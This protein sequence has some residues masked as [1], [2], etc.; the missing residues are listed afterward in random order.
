MLLQEFQHQETITVTNVNTALPRRLGFRSNV[1]G[2]RRLFDLAHACAAGTV[3]GTRERPRL[4]LSLATMPQQARVRFG[5]HLPAVPPASEPVVP[6]VPAMCGAG[7]R[8][9]PKAEPA[10]QRAKAKAK[11]AA[12]PK[13]NA[14]K[15]KNAAGAGRPSSSQESP[16]TVNSS[17]DAEVP[18]ADQEAFMKFEKAWAA[19]HVPGQHLNIRHQYVS[20]AGHHKVI[21]W[22]NSCGPCK[23]KQGW[24]GY[25]AYNL[26]SK[27]VNRTYTPIS[28]HTDFS[29]QKAWTPLTAKTENALKEFM[30]SNLRHTTQDLVAIVE[31]NQEERPSDSWIGTWRKNH[32]KLHPDRAVRLS[33]CK[34]V[35]SDWEQL[36]RD[37]GRMEELLQAPPAEWPS[38]LKFGDCS[39]DP[40]ETCMTL[41]NPALLHETLSR[42]S[43][44]EYIKLCGDGTFRLAT[45]EWVLLTVGALTK[46][47]SVSDGV[48]AF[49][50]TFSP[51]MFALA[52]KESDVSYGTLFDSLISCAKAVAGVDLREAV[53]Q[54]HA[55]LHSGE[56]KARRRCWPRSDRVADFAHVI[57]ACKRPARRA[58]RSW[59]KSDAQVNTWRS[60]LFAVMKKRAQRDPPERA[61]VQALQRHYLT[62]CSPREANDRFGVQSWPG[63]TSHKNLLLADW[64]HGAERLQ[65]GSASGTQAQESWHVHKL[66][67]RLGR[68]HQPIDALVSALQS[69]MQSRLKDLQAR[70]GV[71][72][73]VPV[74]PFPDKYVLHDSARLTLE[75]RTSAHQYFR[76]RS[77]DLWSDGEDTTYYAMRRTYA[78]FDQEAK[79]WSAVR[80]PDEQ[81]Q[82]VR[83][84]TAQ[85]LARLVL[86]TQGT[87]L[88]QALS[89]LGLGPSPLQDL[90]ALL[91][92]MST[93][94]LVVQGP[95]ATKHW[96]RVGGNN[97]H[98]QILCLFCD[99]F[100]I[101]GSCEHAH[102]A[103]LH[104]KQISLTRAEMPRRALKGVAPLCDQEPVP[105]ILPGAA[106]ASHDRPGDE[107][108]RTPKRRDQRLL[109][110]LAAHDFLKWA[111][112]LQ[113]EELTVDQ[114]AS[115]PLAQLKAILPQVPAGT[116]CTIADAAG[117]WS[118]QKA[119]PQLT[120]VHAETALKGEALEDQYAVEGLDKPANASDSVSALTFC[121]CSDVASEERSDSE[122]EEQ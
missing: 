119:G 86:A 60:G 49:R 52:N 43:N 61:A 87:C 108:S 20:Q 35:K 26:E 24:R 38:S 76:T 81:I 94:V 47:Y 84:G 112:L 103:L 59:E 36:R 2:I 63:Q 53:G 55:D 50:T 98:T 106:R 99:S 62:P 69:F 120:V 58:V 22:C 6:V 13:E 44:K 117:S 28:K 115:I 41:C 67:K 82:Q 105:I 97:P 48:Y 80:T 9:A 118:P 42:L 90:N 77:M 68:L 111:P 64:W 46:H 10:L 40:K 75:G 54:Y 45:E 51:L 121:L 34:W 83:P 19:T 116:L 39:E 88:E 93:H 110:F 7:K 18:F 37:Y 12:A 92:C 29:A 85:A 114:L 65:P 33:K 66:K 89:D 27:E 11:S 23:K 1:D 14:P 4:R 30:K 122:K 107:S 17:Y 16:Y 74:E 73:D 57:G 78:T 15:K 70:G 25:S 72:P 3:E 71:L 32:L 104:S 101:A 95:A 31:K 21:L 113:A 5:L 91:K 102:V 8:A 56:E 79:G 96:R 109:G 100:G